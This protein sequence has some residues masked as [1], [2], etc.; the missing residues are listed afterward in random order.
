MLRT[1]GAGYLS[2]H[3]LH[4]FRILVAIIA[5]AIF[6]NLVALFGAFGIDSSYGEEVTGGQWSC[7]IPNIIYAVVIGF[8][9]G[10]FTGFIAKKRG[11]LLGALSQFLPLLAIVLFCLY[12]NRDLLG[13]W[14]VKPA[15]WTWIGLIPAIVGGMCGEHLVNNADA[16]LLLKAIPWHWSWIWLV[17]LMYVFFLAG[18]IRFYLID[19]VMGWEVLFVPRLWIAM[20]FTVP[21]ISSLFYATISLPLLS[22]TMLLALLVKSDDGEQLSNSQRIIGVLFAVIGVP[23]ILILVWWVNSFALDF[24][25]TNGLWI[26]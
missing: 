10:F 26:P 23:I 21:L 24:L 14:Q 25:E 22:M 2:N 9:T 4:T 15:V 7:T 1:N 3:I 8:L 18:S 12:I 5:G 19:L 6:G 13:G 16:I 20:L 11:G 17:L